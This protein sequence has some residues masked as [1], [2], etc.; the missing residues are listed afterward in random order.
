[1]ADTLV[2][3]R[4]A[5]HVAQRGVNEGK[6]APDYHAARPGDVELEAPSSDLVGYVH[7]YEIGSVADGP[8][9][10]FVAILTGCPSRCVYCYNPDTWHKHNGRA[11]TVSRMM[12]T[13]GRY[14][15]ALRRSGGGITL[16]GG[17][18]IVQRAF[19]VDVFR[20]CRALG[21]HTCLDTSGRLG[22][23]LSDSD[24]A[25]IDLH[26]LDIKAGDPA[27][28]ERI[29]GQPLAPTLD[30]AR[31]L[32]ALG[33]PLWIRYPLVPG[34]TDDHDNVERAAAF[35]A[36]LAT[37]E[38]LEVLRFHHMGHDKWDRLGIDNVLRDVAPPD[39][40]LTERVRQQFRAHGLAVH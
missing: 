12:R 3:S 25:T 7:S 33:R 37:V 9:V 32:S 27:V 8:G 30:Y 31:R 13:I 16:S 40:T 21:L 35:C 1:M 19:V 20:R 38:R 23:R 26:L 6:V 34:L 5:F 10:R 4:Y 2:G 22:E 29:T 11:V 39:A 15:D 36:S 14:A 18:P 17:E 24:L 28:H